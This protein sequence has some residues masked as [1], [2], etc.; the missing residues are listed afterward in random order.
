MATLNCTGL[1]QKGYNGG[2]DSSYGSSTEYAGFTADP[3]NRRVAIIKFTTP[4][5]TGISKTLKLKYSAREVYAKNGGHVE[6]RWALCTSDDNKDSYVGTGSAVTDSNQVASGTITHTN[7]TSSYS[8]WEI[9]VSSTSISASTTYYLFLWTKTNNDGY[10]YLMELKGPSNHS[11]KLETYDGV[12]HIYDGTDWK[13]AICW[14]YDGEEWKRAIPW[15]CTAEA[16]G[17]EGTEDYVPAT[18]QTC[19]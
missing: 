8:N 14:I 4:S 19:G 15:V 1:S 7:A 16:E 9:T 6:L 3:V 2:W 10:S 5:F 12:V 18:W 13:T 17:E 11:F